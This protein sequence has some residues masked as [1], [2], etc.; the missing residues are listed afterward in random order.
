MRDTKANK[1]KTAG[2]GTGGSLF[3]STFLEGRYLLYSKECAKV[4][5]FKKRHITHLFYSAYKNFT[6]KKKRAGRFNF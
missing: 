6:R 1:I 2:E 3:G 5:H 4:I